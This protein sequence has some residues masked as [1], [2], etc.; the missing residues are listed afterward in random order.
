MKNNRL[1]HETDLART[2][3]LPKDER[4]IQLRKIR[5]F[6][7]RHSWSPFRACLPGIYQATKSLFDL[8]AVS[9]SDVETAIAMKC[10][11]HPDWLSGNLQV[12]R[13]LFDHVQNQK[14]KSKEWSFGSLPVGYGKSVKFW[15]EF[16]SVK[17]DLPLVDFPDPRR[18]HG[19]TKIA[20]RF[21]FSS[22][23]HHIARGDFDQTRFQIT[24]FPMSDDN[25]RNVRIYPMQ[26][27]EIVDLDTLNL[28]IQETFQMWFEVLEERERE[29]RKSTMTGTGGLFG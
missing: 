29:A 20:R 28:A 19:L 26:M 4:L 1:L 23:F 22:M 21:V 12:A 7:P 9:W 8:P 18:G 24:T 10:K 15:P 16:Y 11:K 6:A 14:L 25:S 5:D 3:L 27:E 2:A 17:D 13:V